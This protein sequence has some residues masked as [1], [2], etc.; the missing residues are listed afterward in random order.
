MVTRDF[1]S[2]IQLVVILFFSLF[3]RA[4]QAQYNRASCVPSKIA[5][6]RGKSIVD[7]G[8]RVSVNNKI[9]AP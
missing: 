8:G 1:P 7:G 5:P 3:G 6:V 4:F 9:Q 2:I